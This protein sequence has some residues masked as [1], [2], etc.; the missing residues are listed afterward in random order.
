MHTSCAISMAFFIQPNRRDRQDLWDISIYSESITREII[1]EEIRDQV[2]QSRNKYKCHCKSNHRQMTQRN[3][4]SRLIDRERERKVKNNYE[5]QQTKESL[6]FFIWDERNCEKIEDKI[7]RCRIMHSN[8]RNENSPE[9]KTSMSMNTCQT[10]LLRHNSR[11]ANIHQ[12]IRLS[13]MLNSHDTWTFFKWFSIAL[14]RKSTFK[15]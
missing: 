14:T 15:C 13:E 7:C 12:H 8:W 2:R 9:F 11:V 6:L 10:F 5:H 4:R 3:K 1:G